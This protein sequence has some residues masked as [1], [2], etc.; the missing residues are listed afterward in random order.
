M[1]LG[2]TLA[3]SAIALSVASLAIAGSVLACSRAGVALPDGGADGAP[4]GTVYLTELRVSSSDDTLTLVPSFSPNI[5]DYYVRCAAG[6]N[7]LTVSIAAAPG[8]ESLVSRPTRSPS[9]PKQT[10][11]LRVS[12]NQAIVAV[13]AAGADSVEY[14]VRCLPHD[15]PAI[16]LD[17]HPQAG[18]PVPGYYLIGN[19]APTVSGN[20]AYAMVVDGQGVPVWYVREPATGVFD[21]DAV[22]SGAISFLEYPSKWSAFEIH[23]LSPLQTGVLSNPSIPLD[24]HE[25]RHLSN[26]DFLVFSDELE[27][28]VDLTGYPLALPDG[29]IETLGPD[30]TIL[31][32]DVLEV[33]PKGTIVWKWVGTDHFDAV[34]DSTF[35]GR[36]PDFLHP[37]GGGPVLDPF[38]CNSIDVDPANGNL[39]VSARNMDSVFY[40]DRS[41]GKVLWKMGGATYSKDG[42]TYVAMR[43][44]FFRQHDARLLPGWSTECGGGHGQLSVFDDES[45]RSQ[46]ARAAVYDVNVG[47]GQGTE[48]GPVG[49]T[50]A[51]AHPGSEN[52]V[53]MGSFRILP[54][55]S[56][57]IGWGQ[58]GAPGLVFSEVDAW[59]DDLLDFYFAGD[60]SSYRAIKVP[61]DAFD[62]DA[63]RSTAGAP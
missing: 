11:S 44:P 21:V 22:V 45:S 33:D 54:D 36:G 10:A 31:P 6:T 50:L 43:D 57:T 37:P 19:D 56:R 39:L 32:C 41:T 58:G 51:W 30:G 53:F 7:A 49:A 3:A 61:L 16:S 38:H 4:L 59:G 63:L 26:G 25:L 48:C 35:P 28:G 2:R 13:A 8:A 27:T 47:E 52:S 46:P 24:P 20:V 12:E 15:F 18:A 40:I 9:A 62:L 1:M 5:H 23:R 29:G 14:W 34:K 55:G 17:A 42:A 60:G